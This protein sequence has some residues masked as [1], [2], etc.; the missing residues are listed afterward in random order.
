M[1]DM[2]RAQVVY[3][4]GLVKE[5][6]VPGDMTVSSFMRHASDFGLVRLIRSL[7]IVRDLNVEVQSGNNVIVLIGRR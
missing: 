7:H 1:S 5:F 3:K 4:Q 2:F 6:I